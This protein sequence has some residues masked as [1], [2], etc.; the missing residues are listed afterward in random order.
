MRQE[1]L[2]RL[3]ILLKER[4]AGSWK[5]GWVY[6]RLKQ[7]FDLQ[8]DELGAIANVLK[9]KYGWNPTVQEL[10]ERQW[11]EE[12]VRWMQHELNKMQEQVALH[13]QKSNISQKIATLLQE[14]EILDAPQQKLTDV[15]R[16]LI[17]L[18]FKM[19]VEEQLWLL[20]TIF[21]RYKF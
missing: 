2:D 7:E 10:L 5:D 21:D 14:Y 6:G 11:Q 17:A 8:P 3:K 9:F 19:N 20:E 12:E 18:I 4:L 1:F 13:Q 16:L 15:E